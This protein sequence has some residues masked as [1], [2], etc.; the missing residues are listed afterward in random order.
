MDV[1]HGAEAPCIIVLDLNPTQYSHDKK[2]ERYTIIQCNIL[3]LIAKQILVI[4]FKLKDHLDNQI[5]GD[6]DIHV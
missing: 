2:Q 5:F 3:E 4:Y 6:S 1:L